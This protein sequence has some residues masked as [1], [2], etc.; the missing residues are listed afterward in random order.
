[1][2]AVHAIRAVESRLRF[3]FDGSVVSL[4]RPVDVSVWEIA[5]AMDDLRERYGEPV[6]IDLTLGSPRPPVPRS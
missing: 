2:Q 5:E 1:M 6:A 4:N 3:V